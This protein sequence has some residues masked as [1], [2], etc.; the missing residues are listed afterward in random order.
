MVI[1]LLAG[2]A[3][4]GAVYFAPARDSILMY[5]GLSCFVIALFWLLQAGILVKNV[6]RATRRQSRFAA[7][8]SAPGTNAVTPDAPTQNEDLPP[9]EII[10][11]CDNNEFQP[12][13]AAEPNGNGYIAE[14]MVENAPAEGPFVTGDEQYEAP[15]N[16]EEVTVIE[17]VSTDLVA[18]G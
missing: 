4:G 1:A 3:G 13:T 10:T 7:E 8:N 15:A 6:I 17:P 12:G 5:A 9:A 14:C 16:P 2:G 11:V 18:Q